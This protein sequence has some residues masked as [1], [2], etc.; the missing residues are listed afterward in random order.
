MMMIIIIKIQLM[1]FKKM[2]RKLINK[3]I[4]IQIKKKQKVLKKMKKLRKNQKNQIKTKRKK[5]SFQ[6]TQQI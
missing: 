1:K 3:L 5:P 2:L 6:K 4:M